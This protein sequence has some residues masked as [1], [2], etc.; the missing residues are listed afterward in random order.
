MGIAVAIVVLPL[1]I[2]FSIVGAKMAA[3]MLTTDQLPEEVFS[4]KAFTGIAV[5]LGGMIA[6]FA[7]IVF[8]LWVA[9]LFEK[10]LDNQYHMLIIAPAIILVGPFVFGIFLSSASNRAKQDTSQEIKRAAAGAFH[11]VIFFPW[12]MMFIGMIASAF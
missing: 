5:Y 9:S 7:F 11:S 10:S 3:A 2:I 12:V 8:L 4:S 6:S 1:Y